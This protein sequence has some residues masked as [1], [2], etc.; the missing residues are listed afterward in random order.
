M[1]DI[2]FRAWNKTKNV[3]ILPKGSLT[4]HDNEGA[5][6]FG[7]Y[8]LQGDSWL[9]D[10]DFIIMQFTGLKDKNGKEIWEGYCQGRG[11]HT[12]I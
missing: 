4:K 3:M 9:M 7:Q 6:H 11:R 5:F 1:R 12:T 8:V 2:K 10:C